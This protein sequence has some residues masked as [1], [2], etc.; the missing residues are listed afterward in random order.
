MSSTPTRQPRRAS[1]TRDLAPEAP[2][3]PGDERDRLHSIRHQVRVFPFP[4]T[5][6]RARNASIARP[7]QDREFRPLGRLSSAAG[8]LVAVDRHIIRM[9]YL[10]DHD[11]AQYWPAEAAA[12][13]PLHNQS[14][15][16]P[17]R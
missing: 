16:I 3:R 17:L 11:R 10:C 13:R 14:P 6:T 1:W 5:S 4:A 12:T 8:R 2:A 9:H 15:S 7:S